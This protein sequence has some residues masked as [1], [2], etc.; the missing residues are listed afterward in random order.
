MRRQTNTVFN[1]GAG[2]FSAGDC[3]VG[4]LM[5]YL[6]TLECQSSQNML[7]LQ[8]DW[9]QVE[10]TLNEVPDMATCPSA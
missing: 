5:Q 2:A 1:Y 4:L 8:D 10:I 7:R 9:F 3:V 6:E